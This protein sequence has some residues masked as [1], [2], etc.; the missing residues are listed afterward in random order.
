[1]PDYWLRSAG[2]TVATDAARADLKPVPHTGM[3]AGGQLTQTT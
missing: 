3:L 2:Y 1:M